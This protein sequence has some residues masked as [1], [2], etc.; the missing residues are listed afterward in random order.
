MNQDTI[1]TVI[2]AL[3]KIGGTYLLAKGFKTESSSIDTLLTDGGAIAALSGFIWGLYSA[4]KDAK[5][6]S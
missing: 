1:A 5:L 3:L 6:K 2:R 4:H